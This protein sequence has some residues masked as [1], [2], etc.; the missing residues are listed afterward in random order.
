MKTLFIV[1]PH[2]PPSS[3]PPS[4][5]VRLLVR[6]AKQFGFFP[7]AYTVNTNYRQ[8][9]TDEWMNEL[10]GDDYLVTEINCLDQRKTR[11][12]G[13]GDLGLRMLPFLIFKLIKDAKKLKADFILYPVP[14]WYILI[15][16]PIVKWFTKVPYGIDFIDPW[17][18]EE[19]A[20]NRNFKYNASQFIAK[21][22][23]KM[24]L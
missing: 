18:H 13:I 22:F 5:R 8:E 11:K 16:A 10:L 6:N 3:L 4:Q 20:T 17:V 19:I 12:F 15:A 2:F 9:T 21:S 24:G 23:R 7:H 1:A 14:P